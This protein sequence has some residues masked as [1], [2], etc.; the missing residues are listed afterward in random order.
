[1]DN[2]IKTSLTTPD[3]SDHPPLIVISKMYR[4]LP[5][6]K[7]TSIPT[8]SF[9]PQDSP[10]SRE[11]HPCSVDEEAEAQRWKYLAQ[12]HRAGVGWS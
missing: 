12:S 6:L 2:K 11:E 5:S 9:P 3:Q 4:A 10:T 7:G 1:M 8:V